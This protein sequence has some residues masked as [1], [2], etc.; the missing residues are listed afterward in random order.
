MATAILKVEGMSCDHCKQA[1]E[2]ALNRVD[3]VKKAVVD[4]EEK[5]ATVEYD[6]VKTA[7][8]IMKEVVEDQGYDVTK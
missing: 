3:G 7:P 6:E 5:T 8:P 2:G 4:L 1:V